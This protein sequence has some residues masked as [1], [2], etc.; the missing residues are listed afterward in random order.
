MCN[1]FLGLFWFVRFG[2]IRSTCEIRT[3]R[4]CFVEMCHLLLGLFGYVKMCNLLLGL[5]WFVKFGLTR[6]TCEI[7]IGL[8]RFEMCVIYY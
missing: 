1:L 3:G 5:F 7:R 6:F 4:F 8:F 2:L